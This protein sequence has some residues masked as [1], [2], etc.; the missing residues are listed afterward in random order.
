MLYTLAAKPTSGVSFK[1]VLSLKKLLGSK[2]IKLMTTDLQISYLSG[3][4]YR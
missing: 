2:Q 1:T 4:M 3:S